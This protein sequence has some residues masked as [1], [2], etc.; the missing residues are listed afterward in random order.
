MDKKNLEKRIGRIALFEIFIL[1]VGILTFAY[2]VGD[3]FKLV[4]A[5]SDIVPKSTTNQGSPKST[6][7]A[8]VNV[9]KLDPDRI[10]EINKNTINMGGYKPEAD[11]LP[12]GGGG[13]IT[14]PELFWGNLANGAF[15]VVMNGLFALGLKWVGEFISTSLGKTKQYGENV[16][17]SLAVGFGLGSLI[18]AIPGLG[19]GITL[20]TFNIGSLALTWTVPWIGIIATG[21]A[22]LGCILFW[23]H[24][25]KAEVVQFQCQAWNPQTKGAYCDKCNTGFFPCTKYKCQSLGMGCELLNEGTNEEKCAWKNSQDIAP[26]TISAWAKVLPEGYVYSPLTAVLPGDKGVIINYTLS[27][28]GCAPAFATMS[29]GIYLDKLGQCKVDTV[30]TK[31]YESMSY[32]LSNA[33]Y[34]RNHS[35]SSFASEVTSKEKADVNVA[36]GGNYEVYVRCSSVN[37]QSN[38]GTFVFKY[39]V[40]KT[41]DTTAPSIKL[42]DPLNNWPIQNGKKS[43]D[44]TVYLDKPSSCKWSHDNIGYDAMPDDNLMD[45]ACSPSIVS[46]NYLYPCTANLTGLKDETNNIF[47]L[48]CKSYNNSACTSSPNGVQT[49]MVESYKYTLIGTKPLV[50]DWVKPNGTTIKDSSINVKVTL[51][52]H[53]SAGYKEGE[54]VCSLSEDDESYVIFANTN[55]YQSSQDLWLAEENYTY[56]VKCCDLGGNCETAPTEFEVETDTESP[57]V[58]RIYNDNN[59]LKIVTDEGAECVYSTTDCNYLFADGLKLTT[60]DNKEHLAEWNTASNLYIKCQDKFGNQPFPNACSIIVR[61]FSEYTSSSATSA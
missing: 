7:P 28:D 43:I 24:D 56:Y 30:R 9:P 41:P 25:A 44:T 31:D 36:N 52:A 57:L 35:I 3:E 33:R 6:T 37:E 27:K 32:S 45:C 18:A 39:C 48:N 55:S 15:N 47:Y 46:S 1:I 42:T 50:L 26:P 34:K 13:E 29:Y 22:L 2:F 54:S 38:V 49:A 14:N 61:P 21:L 8:P 20:A 40:Q 4:S 23:C 10:I 51:E 16:G 17:T 59:K 12:E 60:S 5:T 53:T 11:G 58:I 19:G